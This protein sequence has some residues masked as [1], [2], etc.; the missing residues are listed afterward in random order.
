MAKANKSSKAK[1]IVFHNV[2]ECAAAWSIAVAEYAEGESIV[3]NAKAAFSAAKRQ[4]EITARDTRNSGL[5]VGKSRRT[6]KIAAAIH[7]G[8]TATGYA[9]T[10]AAQIL[11]R[12]RHFVDTGKWPANGKKK[13]TTQQGPISGF[14]FELKPG[15]KSETVGNKVKALSEYL[16]AEYGNDETMLRIAAYLADVDEA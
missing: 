14:T 6:C 16:K 12:I 13:P 8:L 9:E 11:S 15:A 3:D 7:D 2:E 10:S 4:V 5:K 1:V